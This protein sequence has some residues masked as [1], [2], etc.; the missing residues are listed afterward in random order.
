M[1][2]LGNCAKSGNCATARRPDAHDKLHRQ[3]DRAAVV[4]K[5]EEKNDK[6]QQNLVRIY[7]IFRNRHSMHA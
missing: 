5:G 3:R 2:R 7:G 1:W 6:R 4:I